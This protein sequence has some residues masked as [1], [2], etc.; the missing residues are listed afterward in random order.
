MRLSP[1]VWIAFIA[2]GLVA[3][4]N[5][6]IGA[7]SG[8]NL[9]IDVFE[10]VYWGQEGVTISTKHPV[11]YAWIYHHWHELFGNSDL[12]GFSIGAV[13]AILGAALFIILLR[14]LG[15]SQTAIATSLWL[16][17][18]ST[19]WLLVVVIYNANSATLPLWMLTFLGLWK[20]LNRGHLLWWAL[21]GLAASLA[22]LTKYHAA[23]LLLSAFIWLF[24]G[25]E[26][27]RL[28]RTPGPY[29]AASIFLAIVGYHVAELAFWGWPSL[30]FSGQRVARNADL[31]GH[32]WAH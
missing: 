8:Q 22:M 3:L 5:V 29:V 27:R 20:G 30:G 15:F 12:S 4:A 24:M 25:P 7:L 18:A 32:F 10:A 6:F 19:N 11:F 16:I 13:N 21:A 9:S 23:F 31:M 17:L 14:Q 28:W 26:E 2:L 1:S